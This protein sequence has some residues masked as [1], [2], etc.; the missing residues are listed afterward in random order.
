MSASE[1][2]YRYKFLKMDNN[3]LI[4]FVFDRLTGEVKMVKVQEL[5]RK[6]EE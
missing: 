1:S 4:A 3:S 6:N 2:K 5:E